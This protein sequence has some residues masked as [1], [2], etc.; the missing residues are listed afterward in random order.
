MYHGKSYS[1]VHLHAEEQNNVHNSCWWSCNVSRANETVFVLLYCYHFLQ[2]ITGKQLFALKGL[3]K[4][5]K[6]Q[7]KKWSIFT[8]NVSPSNHITE[9]AKDLVKLSRSPSSSCTF[10]GYTY[11]YLS[12]SLPKSNLF[13]LALLEVKYSSYTHAMCCCF[14]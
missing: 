7:K 14:V 2:S 13:T 5:R 8:I 9:S 3:L 10:L 1:V 11:P 12:L 4:W 6:L